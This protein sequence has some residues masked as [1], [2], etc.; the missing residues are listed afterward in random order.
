DRAW[1][2]LIV[3]AEDELLPFLSVMSSID[4]LH[5]MTRDERDLDGVLVPGSDHLTT[6]NLYAEA[7]RR[8]GSMG[9][10]YGLPRHVFD[11]ESIELWAERRGV[12][13]KSIED[14]ALAMASVYRGVDVPL[15]TSMPWAGARVHRRFA[16]LVARFMPF[17]LVIDEETA[18][19]ES[20]RVSRRSVAGS[21]GAVA[22]TLRYFADRFGVSRASI[23]GTQLPADLVRQYAVRGAD[24]LVY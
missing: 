14:A 7:F 15:P 18:S 21:W 17:D 13:V 11:A 16:D 20:A 3:H 23:E 9:E 22:G 8:A 5:R 1:A 6:Y 4:S 19:G 12:L 2:E 24:D 10:V